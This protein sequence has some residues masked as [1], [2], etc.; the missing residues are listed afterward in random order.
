MRKDDMLRASIYELD[1]VSPHIN[2]IGALR[3]LI[4]DVSNLLHDALEVCQE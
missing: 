4:K 3:V 1:R 2:E